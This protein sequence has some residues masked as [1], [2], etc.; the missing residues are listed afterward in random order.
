[1]IAKPPLHIPALGTMAH[2]WVQMFPTEEEAFRNYA[3]TYPDNCTCQQN[4]CFQKLCLD[5]W[6]PYRKQRFS[7][8]YGHTLW[9]R[10]RSMILWK[11]TAAFMTVGIL[12]LME[13][14]KQISC[15]CNGFWRVRQT[16]AEGFSCKN[17]Q[18][19]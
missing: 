6:P 18:H 16:V 15:D 13:I 14:Q 9:N 4:H 12:Y 17:L 11:N 2:S 19:G 8:K 5:C 3:R 1:M 10:P 7:R